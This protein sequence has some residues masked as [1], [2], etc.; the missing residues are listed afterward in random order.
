MLI[1]LDL[2]DKRVLIVGGGD[3]GERKTAKIVEEC[4]KIVVASKDFTDGLKQLREDKRVELVTLD[5]KKDFK[6][7]ANMIS[8]ADIV[9]IA[10]DDHRLNEDITRRTKR[11]GVLICTVDNPSQ[12]NFSFPAVTSFKGIEVAIH[13]RGRSPLMSK[14]LRERIEGVITTEDLLQVELQQYAR[15]LVK[16]KIPKADERKSILYKIA[17]NEEVERLLKK[18]LFDEAKVVAKE[19][20]ERA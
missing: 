14:I 7:L 3:V 4:S 18:G 10:T 8:N 1:N 15:N 13:T 2:T 17:Q 5:N 6:L 11:K 12:S 20:I 9:I 16:T 19:I